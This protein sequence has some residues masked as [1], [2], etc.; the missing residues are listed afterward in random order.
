MIIDTNSTFNTDRTFVLAAIID[1]AS[2]TPNV[3]IRANRQRK[4]QSKLV[5]Q[6]QLLSI[7]QT[8]D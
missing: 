1:M 5:A 4:L 8:F 6:D 2:P 3:Y 7:S